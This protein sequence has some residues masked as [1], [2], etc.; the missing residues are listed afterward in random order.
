MTDQRLVTV[1]TRRC[2]VCG[3]TGE[4]TVSLAGLRAWEAGAF[5]QD[6]FPTLTPGEREQILNGTHDACFESMFPEEH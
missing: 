5:I 4:V 6:A 2:I 3:K 1:E